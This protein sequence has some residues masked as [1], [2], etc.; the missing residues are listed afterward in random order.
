[1]EPTRARGVLVER[2]TVGDGNI[3]RSASVSRS[4]YLQ[5]A[6]NVVKAEIKE[7][8]GMTRLASLH[9]FREPFSIQYTAPTCSNHYATV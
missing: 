4:V 5:K 9:Y 6:T 8:I 3:Q 1:M 2:Q 7:S